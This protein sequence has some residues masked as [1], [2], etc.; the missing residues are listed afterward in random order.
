MSIYG[1]VPSGAV[2]GTNTVFTTS[3]PYYAGSTRVYLGTNA[4]DCYR[5]EKGVAYTETTP[6]SGVLTLTTAPASGAVLLV[7]YDVTAAGINYPVGVW[8]WNPEGYPAGAVL[9]YG[10]VLWPA[11]IDPGS[12]QTAVMVL[13][14]GGA[15]VTGMPALAAG[16]P[17]QSV[18]LTVGTV[19][20][21]AA[22]DDATFALDETSPGGS[23]VAS[24]YTVN[25]GIPEGPAGEAGVFSIA[26]AEDLAGTL[27]NLVTL[28]YNSATSKFNPTPLPFLFA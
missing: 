19:S 25:V 28:V 22:G 2:N 10:P 11:G 13:G 26:G 17:G 23:G 6:A 16:P 5:L 1:E 4:S 21:L 8:D 14:P 27:T 18:Q 7:D 3:Q 9:Y 12:T 20:T 24:A 15:Q